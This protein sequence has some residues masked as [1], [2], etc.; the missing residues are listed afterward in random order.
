MRFILSCAALMV[1]AV[2]FAAEEEKIPDNVVKWIEKCK[3]QQKVSNRAVTADLQTF[4]AQHAKA[5]RVDKGKLAKRLKEAQAA[6]DKAFAADPVAYA[7]SVAMPPG[8][9]VGAIGY[10]YGVTVVRVLDKSSAVVSMDGLK[11]VILTGVDT[12][13]WPHGVKVDVEAVFEVT[14]IDEKRDRLPVLR[15]FDPKKWARKDQPE[16]KPKKK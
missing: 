15:P 14:G 11:E 4:T 16:D 13:D 2:A 6:Y 9:T 5:N 7:E 1:V 3:D 12:K 10:V 8:P